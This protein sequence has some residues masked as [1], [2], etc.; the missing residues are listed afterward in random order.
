[1][2]VNSLLLP[3]LHSSVSL[4][5]PTKSSIKLQ[6]T[7]SVVEIE[8]SRK[9]RDVRDTPKRSA[10]QTVDF[11]AFA[12][13]L[14]D[15]LQ[16]GMDGYDT[17]EVDLSDFIVSDDASEEELRRPRGV[18]K[19]S[20]KSYPT[21]DDGSGPENDAVYTKSKARPVVIDLISPTKPSGTTTSHRPQ[22][23]ASKQDPHEESPDDPEAC[24]KLY[25][26][27]LPLTK[28]EQHHS[29]PSSSPPRSRSPRKTTSSPHK[30][31][32][33][34]RPLTPP[35]ITTPPTSPSKPRLQSPSKT[36]HARI[37]LSPHRPSLDAFWSASEIN[38]WNDTYSPRKSPVRRQLFP[39]N[40]E[41]EN[42][43]SPSTSP[44]KTRSPTKTPAKKD[45]E[46]IARKKAFETSKHALAE[47][48]L[49]ELDDTITSGQ[50]SALAASTGGVKLVWSKKLNSTAGRATW[51]REALRPK[52]PS[53][54]STP[55]TSTSTLALALTSA[56]TSTST[57]TS[58][59]TATA[60]ATSAPTYRH[61][62]TI[63]LATKVITTPSRLLNVLAHEY[64]HLANFMIS[65]I[66]DQPHGREFKIW[67][68][69][70]S[71]KFAERGVRVTT[72]HEYV[73]EYKYIWACGACGVEYKR[74]SR[75][76]DPA[77]Q[78][79]GS[80]KEAL[81]QVL[82][83]PR[84]GGGRVGG[85][86][87]VGGNEGAGGTGE[88]P[89]RSAY[90]IYVKTH[91]AT[92]KKENPTLGMGEIMVLLGRG[93]REEK[94]RRV[95]VEEAGEDNGGEVVVVSDGEGDENEEI[96]GLGGGGVGDGDLDGVARKLDFLSLRAE[97]R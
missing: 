47:E 34:T 50:V 48:F 89:M 90:Q 51:K 62:A 14:R 26:L 42:S 84:G 35:L 74:H 16:E 72:K 31:A 5:S 82:P 41:S 4:G 32:T 15:A 69:K 85:S 87:G 83:V 30:P 63:E 6:T 1:V 93:Y 39:L 81:V 58:T 44:S 71:D 61:H 46:A 28:P 57:S 65:G 12:E 36:P 49:K 37:P 33:T 11:R 97:S 10:A 8:K 70:V 56:P 67:A 13:D 7:V 91:Y 73:I 95:V 55:T 53:S 54:S 2:H 79:C 60:T 9:G 92:V 24:L 88:T 66:K 80:C 40:E 78:R 25:V 68:R 64:C 23:H 59:S 96:G 27:L 19:S 22:K 20:K 29:Q 17:E 94:A 18:G 77:R 43:V 76:I 52:P 86:G 75:S 3:L 21:E 38:D 45:K